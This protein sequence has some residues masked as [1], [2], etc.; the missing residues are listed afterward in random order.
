MSDAIGNA[1]S[2]QIVSVNDR[3]GFVD[4]IAAIAADAD[5]QCVLGYQNRLRAVEQF[6]LDRMVARYEQ[7]YESLERIPRPSP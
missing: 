3:A 7:V 4:R 2:R 6:G 1:Q 5:L